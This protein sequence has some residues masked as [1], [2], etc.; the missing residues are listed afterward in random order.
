MSIEITVPLIV[1]A[2]LSFDVEPGEIVTRKMIDAA[3][4]A[5]Q[6]Y[7]DKWGPTDEG[8]GVKVYTQIVDFDRNLPIECYDRE[9]DVTFDLPENG[10]TTAPDTEQAAS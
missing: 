10:N 9:A 5:W 1:N 4:D 2:G 8:T 6:A 7:I 3:I